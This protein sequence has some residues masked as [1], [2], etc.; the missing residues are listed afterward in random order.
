M[1]KIWQDT[2]DWGLTTLTD[3]SKASSPPQTL[4]DTKV[5][6]TVWGEA[7]PPPITQLGQMVLTTHHRIKENLTQ[8]PPLQSTRRVVGAKHR[9]YQTS[10]EFP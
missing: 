7:T 5:Q 1:R 10:L 4:Q 2:R 9:G 8:P 6:K 3:E